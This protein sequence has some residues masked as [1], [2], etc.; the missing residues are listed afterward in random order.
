MFFMFGEKVAQK[1]KKSQKLQML[2]MFGENVAHK[3]TKKSQKSQM[4]FMFEENVAQKRKKVAKV[5][6]VALHKTTF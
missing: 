3:I 4:Q 5:T 2:V 1:K 6:N